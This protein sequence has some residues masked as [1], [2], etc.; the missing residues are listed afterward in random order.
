MYFLL[1][2]A[3]FNRRSHQISRRFYK[4]LLCANV[5]LEN[6]KSTKNIIRSADLVKPQNLRKIR[7]KS[8]QIQTINFI[9]QKPL[10]DQ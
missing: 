4:G 10:N 1:Y 8:H 9:K 6:K 3:S 7:R 2:L 5:I